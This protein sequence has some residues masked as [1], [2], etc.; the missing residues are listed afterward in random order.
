M[1]PKR[2][3]IAVLMIASLGAAVASCETP[4]GTFPRAEDLTVQPKPV[5]AD[6]VLASRV[7]GERYDNAVEAWGEDGWAQVGRLCRFFDEMGMKGL[8]CPP[9]AVPPRP[10]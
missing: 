6:D 1:L 3:P 7:A 9:P 4:A 5:P 2:F 10:G 8:N